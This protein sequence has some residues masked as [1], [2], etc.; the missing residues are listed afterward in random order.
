[1]VP[2][3]VGDI[4]AEGRVGIVH[5]SYW[6]ASP[7]K[8]AEMTRLILNLE[9]ADQRLKNTSIESRKGIR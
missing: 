2:F 3:V 5:R 7:W 6:E 4:V 9:A 1:M 8:L